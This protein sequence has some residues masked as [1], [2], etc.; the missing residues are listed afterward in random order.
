MTAAKGYSMSS[1]VKQGIYAI[2]AVVGLIATWYFNLQAMA[3]NP[4]F[5]ILT[6]LRDNYVNPSSASIT[7]DIAVVCLAFFFWSFHEARRLG[8]RFWWAYVPM[9]LIIA[10]AVSFP[11]FLLMRERKL[12]EQA[13]TG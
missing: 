5:S 8:M 1:S 2:L 9:T 6:F 13:S 7:N 12:E 3:A 10:L 11:F 4:D